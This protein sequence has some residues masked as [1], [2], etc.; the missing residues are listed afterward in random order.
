MARER[1]VGLGH[2]LRCSPDEAP[3][4]DATETKPAV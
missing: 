4:I 3:L 2:V 1:F